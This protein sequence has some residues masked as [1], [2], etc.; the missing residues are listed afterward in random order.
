MDSDQKKY[1]EHTTGIGYFHSHLS[2]IPVVLIS[3]HED[4]WENNRTV[5]N[6]IKR[7]ISTRVRGGTTI[8]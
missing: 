8:I 3:L 6:G 5:C 2:S 4:D 7:S 1:D